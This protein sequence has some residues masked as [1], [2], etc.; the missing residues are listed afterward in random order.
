MVFKYNVFTLPILLS[1]SLISGAF[2][3][4]KILKSFLNN[5]QVHLAIPTILLSINKTDSL[6]Q[7]KTTKIVPQV[8]QKVFSRNSS[9]EVYTATRKGRGFADIKIKG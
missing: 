5:K 4:G 1:N 7:I 3:K 2:P 9:N 8:F 6:N